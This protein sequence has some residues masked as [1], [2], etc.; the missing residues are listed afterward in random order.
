M[1]KTKGETLKPANQNG[2]GPLA[3]AGVD[4]TPNNLKGLAKAFAPVIEFRAVKELKIN[5]RNAR[6][7]NNHQVQQIAAS[8]SEFGWL[9]PI[10]VDEEGTVLAGHG[11]LRAALLLDIKTVPTIQV[12]HLTP[13]RKRAFMLAD[14][15]L[16]EL[17][18]WDEELLGIE[19]KE[20]SGLELDFDFE[21]TGFETRD[22]DRLD[23]P[24]KSTKA[25]IVPELDR[26]HPSV[27]SSG[28][29]WKL[30]PHLLLCGN[31][32]EE[33]S[34]AKLMGE[35]RAQMVFTDPPYNVKIDGHV[36]GLGSVHHRP[37]EMAAGEMSESEFTRFLATAM[38]LM[39]QYSGDGAIHDICMDWRHMG[40]VM[41]AAKGIYSEQKNL[42]VWNKTNAGMG[43]FYRS[44]H[45]LVLIFKV[46]TAPHVNNFGLGGSGRYRTNVWD[47]AGV[48]TS[49]RGRMAELTMHPTVKPLP[50][51]VDALK[52]CSTRRG[53]VLDPFLGSG[54]TLLAAEKTGRIGRGI[55]LDPYYVDAAIGRWQVLT[56]ELAVHVE[57]GRTFDQMPNAPLRDSAAA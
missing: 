14:N 2:P 18:E 43:A 10:V 4:S 35:Q 21:V 24:V 6:T 53:I 28:D 37:F 56:G 32:L 57:S 46:G 20:L 9:A 26:D 11:R 23:A 34:Y 27:S 51:V 45:E 38:A 44:K 5:R 36:C 13:E 49:K 33:A 7:H 1:T 48:N 39:A 42:C 40:E 16:A 12:K 50:L 15:R 47:Y 29:L 25:E 17:A 31:A 30:G 54:T 8:V 22:L 52:D 55:E 19:L 3:I 41:A